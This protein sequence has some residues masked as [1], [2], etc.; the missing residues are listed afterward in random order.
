M[1]DFLFFYFYFYFYFLLFRSM[2]TIGLMAH[3]STRY[4]GLASRPQWGRS[5]GLNCLLP[6]SWANDE[7]GC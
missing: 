1:G 2:K 6:T 4:Y 3:I 7:S 5:A